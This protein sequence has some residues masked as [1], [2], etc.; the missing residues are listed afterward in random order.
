MTPASLLH[1]V[2]LDGAGGVE[3]QFVEFLQAAA[4]LA[5]T[6]HAVVACGRAVHPLVRERLSSSRVDVA[7]EKY[8]GR[9]KLP[10]WPEAIRTAHQR[11]IV[12]RE[13]PDIVLIW[14]RLR[15]S[16]HTL[17]AAGAERCVYWERGASW[18]PGESAAKRH[19]L[20]AVPAIL[21]NSHAARRMLELRWGY[22]GSIRVVP[23]ALRPSLK[24]T[25]V[26]PRRI[27]GDGPLRLG[28]VARLAPIK[29]VAL[30]IQAVAL[31]RDAGRDVTLRVA[32]DGPERA[33]LEA[34]VERL[35][36]G[37]RVVFEGLVANMGRFYRHIDLLVHPALREPFGQIAVEAN[38]YGCPAVVAAVDGL[39]EVVDDGATGLCLAPT[40]PLTDYTAL[41]GHDHDLPPFVYD[42]VNDDIAEPRLVDPTRL[43]NAIATLMDDPER[44]AAM[45]ARAIETV[46]RRFAF[47][48]HV[49]DALGALGQFREYG[50]LTAASRTA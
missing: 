17:A 46:D 42:P 13:R 50:G 44:Y 32:G 28:A 41:G 45:S 20:A 12:R 49:R 40:L 22:A 11:R 14:N 31:L 24:P 6:R 27:A 26:R 39:V 9:F 29:G 36:L 15:D 23:N 2:S 10:K 30:A 43:A 48:D 21:C 4:R 25:N 5:E 16:L 7:Y 8:A 38:A 34:L 35:A 33:R 37:D 47:D 18:F 3:L 1:Y 19:F